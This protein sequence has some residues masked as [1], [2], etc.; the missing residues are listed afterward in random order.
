MAESCQR[1]RSAALGRRRHTACTWLFST[2]LLSLIRYI[3]RRSPTTALFY[4]PAQPLGSNARV[5]TNGSCW[6][7]EHTVSSAITLQPGPPCLLSL[8]LTRLL[9]L[10]SPNGIQGRGNFQPS[11]HHQPHIVTQPSAISSSAPQGLQLILTAIP[12]MSDPCPRVGMRLCL[13]CQQGSR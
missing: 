3:S 4:P 1:T 10:S 2:S 8:L 9:R 11:I 7:E 6:Q 13:A 5:A 12:R